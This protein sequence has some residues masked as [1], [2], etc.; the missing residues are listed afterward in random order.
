MPG[1]ALW[2]WIGRVVCAAVV[3]GL[4]I[5]LFAVG[6]DQADKIASA[7]AAVAAL[8][9]LGAPYLLPAPQPPRNTHIRVSDTGNAT[10][11]GSGS[12]NTGVRARQAPAG[13]VTVERTGRADATDGD[14]N[15][16]A[17][18]D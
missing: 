13:D 11:R 6:L 18:L 16:G 2:I 10:V 15:T 14:A 5:Y 4:V 9:A 8:L 7:V 17:D 3:V 1:R 12:A